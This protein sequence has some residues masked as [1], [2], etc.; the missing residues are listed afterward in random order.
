MIMQYLGLPLKYETSKTLAPPSL[1]AVGG[2]CV[3]CVGV[4]CY[5]VFRNAAL[6]CVT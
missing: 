4:K 6:R 5:Y 3:M 1:A 2:E